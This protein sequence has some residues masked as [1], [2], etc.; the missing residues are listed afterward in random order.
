MRA[1]RGQI[2]NPQGEFFFGEIEI[3]GSKITNISALSKESLSS[4]EQE[5]LIIPG[6]VDIHTHGCFGHDTCDASYEGEKSIVDYEKSHGITSFCPTTMTLDEDT[7]TK[8]CKNIAEVKKTTD[9]IKGIYLEG[10]FISEGK[11]GAQ[12]PKYIMKPDYDMIARL[13]DA[14]GGIVKV[15]AIAPEVE[16]ALEV[17]K[18]GSNQFRFS[19]AHTEANVDEAAAA[20]EAGAKHVTHLYNAMPAYSHRAPGVIGAAADSDDTRVELICDGIHIHPAVIK[21]T[22]KLF[23]PERVILISDSMEATGMPNGT[24]SLGG[25]TVHMKDRRAT[26][27][28]GTIAGS[29]SNLYDCLSYAISIGV[30]KASA[31]FAATRNPAKEIGIYEE[32]GSIEIGK[33]SDILIISKDFELQNVIQCEED[34]I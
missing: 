34:I 18:K 29:A 5:R 24:Y 11:K 32:V 17:I 2:F 33:A 25:Q 30:D 6:L 12:N 28:D 23:G 9:V 1:I 26:L 4:E 22:F 20:I 13:N 7:L 15:V 8:I 10:P 19:I 14:S 31:I 21:N 16:G 3:S 27:D